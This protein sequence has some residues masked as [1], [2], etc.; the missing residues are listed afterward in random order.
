MKRLFLVILC[1]LAFPVVA[2]HIVGGEFELIHVSGNFY[3]LNLIVY[4]DKIWGSP[5]AKDQLPV[6]TIYR[7]SDGSRMRDVSLILTSETAVAYTQPEC[8]NDGLSTDRIY[9]TALITLPDNEYNDPGGYYVSWQRC[10]R[11]YQID[12][13]YSDEP[14]VGS[15]NWPTS[16][17]QTF[18]LEFP[19]VVKNGQPFIN[20]SPR[21]FPPLSDYGCPGRQYYVDFAGTDDDDDSL[22]YSMTTPLNTFTSAANPTPAPGPYP[23]ILW[24]PGFSLEHIMR[25]T[26]DLKISKD[27]LLTVT[28]EYTGLFVFAVKVEEYRDKVKI[29]ESRRDF[30]MLVTDGC[31][32]AD[33][34]QIVGRKL[35]ETSFPYDENMSV[36]FPAT[37]ADADRKIIVRVSDPDASKASQGF[38]EKVKIRVIP[39]NFQNE[40][41]RELLPSVTNA[42]LSNGSTK[43]FTISFPK[44]PYFKGGPYQ[45]GII[46]MDDACSLPLLDT[47]KVAVDVEPPPNERAQF[48]T[49]SVTIGQLN[50]GEEGSWPFEARD[51]E[52]EKVFFFVLTDGF[53]FN[54][55][56]MK[57]TMETGLSDM[58]TGKLKGTLDWDAF[59]DIYNFNNRTNF[60]VRLLVDDDDVCDFNDPD[61]ATYKLNVVLPG[62]ANPIVD[63][64]L[65][66]DPQET[67]VTGMDKKLNTDWSFTVTAKDIIDNDFLS[68][69]MIGKDFKP[70]DYGMSFPKKLGRGSL[71]STFQWNLRCDKI[72]LTKKDLFH[73]QFLAVDSTNKCRMLK[74]DTVNVYAKILPADNAE[75]TLSIASLNDRVPFTNN[76][77]TAYLGEG[78]NLEF[79]G[80]DTDEFP[81]QDPLA[82]ELID[83]EGDYPPQGYTFTP[84]TGTSGLK[85]SF[86]WSPDCSIFLNDI[87][88]NNYHFS[89][90]VTSSRC[91]VLSADTVDVSMQIKD[92]QGGILFGDPPNVFTPNGDSQNDYY[93]M[94]KLDEQG[95]RVSLI[96]PDSCT[97]SF[98]MIQIF[99][100]WGKVVFESTDRDFK[101][102]GKNE[103]AGVYYYYLKFTNKE[104]KG[105]VH[106]QF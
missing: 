83:A 47:L 12:N 37:T 66:T 39:L 55:A 2:S 31:P 38:L 81:A 105:S 36:S 106:L 19:P 17:G 70:S 28:P 16:A 86:S 34:P 84:V 11:N 62:N 15:S 13:I 102:F 27:G 50:E 61:T 9:Y 40:D 20:S 1:L 82:I 73:L 30:Q 22:V 95:N 24:K 65:T 87:Y 25:G 96:P 14:P 103:P 76:Q 10:C 104:Y 52:G 59:C 64:N 46:A 94:E 78:I 63:T 45:I 99:N 88:E 49:P 26:P 57:T 77:L 69:R 85:T 48:I 42:T 92:Y 71:E 32:D 53:D 51:P 80:T 23:D 54:T 67:I 68:L 89:F 91:G 93:A 6:A 44:C 74:A 58:L 7:K 8:S 56:G 3:R 35:T 33:P 29:G 79:T 97:G 5:Q 75:P 60:Q 43:D 98:V 4:F 18:Y 72:D 41:L 101:W 100:R 21:L 90:R